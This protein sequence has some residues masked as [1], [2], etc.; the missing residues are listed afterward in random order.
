MGLTTRVFRSIGTVPRC[1]A[2]GGADGTV[3]ATFFRDD[4]GG[5]RWAILTPV[6]PAAEVAIA[7]AESVAGTES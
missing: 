6:R 4:A 5:V 3:V 7:A 1:R 2:A